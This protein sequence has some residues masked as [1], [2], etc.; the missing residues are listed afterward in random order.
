MDTDPP[1][2]IVARD[3]L[4]AVGEVMLRW[5]YL[6]TA[7]LKALG[8]PSRKRIVQ[9]WQEMAKPDVEVVEAIDAA[10]AVRHLLAHGLCE[11]QAQPGH[12]GEAEVVCRD[13]DDALAPITLG[14]L[15][16]V[17][18]SLDRLRL[19]IEAANRA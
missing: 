9:R 7:M 10:T 4:A 16:E 12:G 6:E 17:A 3:L 14:R 18:Q 5:G 8:D 11:I 19:A 1:D 2:K 13:P 15:R